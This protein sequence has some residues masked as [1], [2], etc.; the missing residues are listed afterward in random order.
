[1]QGQKVERELQV[2]A[3]LLESQAF[4]VL[5]DLEVQRVLPENADLLDHP[6]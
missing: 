2:G 5:Q 1:L 4:L 6:V 3:D